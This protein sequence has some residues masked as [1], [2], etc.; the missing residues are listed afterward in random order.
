M[1][2]HRKSESGHTGINMNAVILFSLLIGESPYDELADKLV[3]D[4]LSLYWGPLPG[5]HGRLVVF[6]CEITHTV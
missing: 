2:L 4:Q 6:L 3:R 1:R 5:Y